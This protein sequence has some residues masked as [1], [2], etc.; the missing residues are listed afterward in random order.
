MTNG[1][2]AT[3]VY[4]SKKKLIKNPTFIYTNMVAVISSEN[5]LFTIIFKLPLHLVRHSM[6]ASSAGALLHISPY[7]DSCQLR[8]GI[9]CF[10]F[11]TE[12]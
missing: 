5:G 12:P 7:M 6:I 9:L 8:Q 2:A 10:C 3:L 11:R 1:M 4:I